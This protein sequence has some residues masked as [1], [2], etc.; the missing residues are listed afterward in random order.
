MHIVSGRT[1]RTKLNGLFVSFSCWHSVW[2]DSIQYSAGLVIIEFTINSQTQMQ[3][4]TIVREDFSSGRFKSHIRMIRILVTFLLI[5]LFFSHVGWLLRRSHPDF[6][7]QSN[8]VYVEDL[9]KDPIVYWQHKFYRE[10][11]LLFFLIIPTFIPCILWNESLW[12]SFTFAVGL[13]YVLCL[14]CTWFVNSAAH[15]FGE[16]P[17]NPKIEPRQNPLVSF[18][19]MGEGYH[20]YHHTFPYDY[21]TVE[22]GFIGFNPTKQFIDLMYLLGQ[23]YNLKVARN[24]K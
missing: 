16:R 5:C 20:N 12:T 2:L 18:G 22:F 13:R 21:S 23:A 9:L 3:I 7:I 24:R 11:M 6:L 15:M 10:L 1:S 19:A 14:H 8:K 17:Y 4:L